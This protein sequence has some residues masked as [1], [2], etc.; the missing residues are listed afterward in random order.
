[1]KTI[2]ILGSTGS[3][4]TQ[5][6][7]IIRANSDL[8]VCALSANNNIDLL[9][10]QISE[11]S[12]NFVCVYSKNNAEILKTK[13]KECS[14]EILNKIEICSGMEGLIKAAEY[15]E[16]D[17][18]LTAI[19]GMVGIRPT[20]AAIK[21]GKNVALANKETLV[22]A[23]K[24]I[25][26]AARDYNV[27]IYPVDSEHSAIFQSLN[28]ENRSEADKIL[29][30]ASGG[31]FRGKTTD[32]LQNVTVEQALNH[33]NWKMGRKITIDSATLANKGLEVIEARWLFD[34]P[35]ENIQVV[36]HPQSIIHS[37]VQYKDGAVIAQL[38]TPDMKIPIQYAFY[39]P[40]RR[41][42]EGKRLD[43]FEIE[44]LTFERPDVQTFKALALA[45]K[46][47]EIGG[48]MP[49]VFN[50]ANEL[51]VKRFLNGE[52]KFLDIADFIESKMSAH[53]V[54]ADPTLEQIIKTGEDIINELC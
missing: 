30:T 38:G 33:P 5:A 35:A 25:M 19:V 23:G 12:P 3:I 39:Y 47:L 4:G 26:Q 44:T 31:P 51:A 13:L 11:F 28:G 17:I 40:E 46:A 37:A 52:I 41:Y 7:Q 24:L 50:A 54:I 21:A 6:L 53:E 8:R 45:Y 18:V 10:E 9:I 32:E 16:A 42:L 49:C 2:S 34:M 14:P 15:P 27:H 36:V 20:M 43:L 48:T 1:M 22:C 29:L